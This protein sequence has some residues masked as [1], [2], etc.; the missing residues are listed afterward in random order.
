MANNSFRVEID[1]SDVIRAIEGL[2]SETKKVIENFLKQEALAW[3]RDIKKKL[4]DNNSVVTGDLRRSI[5][6]QPKTARNRWEYVVGTN[7][8][9]APYVEYGTRRNGYRGKPYFQ[10]VYDARAKKFKE[11]MT[12][13]LR[14]ALR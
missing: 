10:P 4:T 7:L 3:Q 8:F 6:V 9:Y 2:G 14:E 1:D 13:I 5:V 11:N 12:Q